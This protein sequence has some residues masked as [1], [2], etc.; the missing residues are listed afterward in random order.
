MKTSLKE[1]EKICK[2]M[3]EKSERK[4]ENTEEKSDKKEP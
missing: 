3:M 2:L 1:L 4:D